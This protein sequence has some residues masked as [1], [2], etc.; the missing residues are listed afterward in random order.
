MLLDRFQSFHIASQSPKTFA[1]GGGT[2]LGTSDAVLRWNK[3]RP[4]QVATWDVVPH[5]GK[6]LQVSW[7]TEEAWGWMRFG[8]IE[9]RRK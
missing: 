4:P 9:E 3:L 5:G 8:E 2:L 7:S 6:I 1:K